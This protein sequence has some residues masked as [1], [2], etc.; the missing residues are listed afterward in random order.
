VGARVSRP[1]LTLPVAFTQSVI[2]KVER[3]LEVL[4]ALEGDPFL[5]RM[6]VLHGGTALN[7]FHDEVPRLSVDIDLM[8]TGA[9]DL[10]T[11]REMRPQVDTR[12]RGVVAALGYAVQ[13]TNDEH[14]GQTYRVKYGDEYIK[15]DVSYLARVALLDPELPRCS[16]ADPPVVFPTLRLPELVSGKIKAL[17]ERR[18]AR[19]LYDLYR[20]SC[21]EPGLLEDP[22]A[23][24]L[25]VRAV[26]V[27]DPFPRVRTPS[28]VLDVLESPPSEYTEPLLAMLPAG[29]RPDYAEMLGA[30]RRWLSALDVTTA[31]E[32]EFMRLLDE[33][34]EYRPQL[35]FAAWPDVLKRA[36]MDP[37]MAWKLRNL[38][39][40]SRNGK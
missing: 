9:V 32:A 37:V 22:L 10:E 35:L 5:G 19:D 31:A 25:A 13:G 16:L 26:S 17:V 20:L 28:Q 24:A 40:R 39:R 4:S 7:L 3:L 34:A 12:F 8:F 30:V 2:E 14:S 6:F 11:M 38:S 33:E 18:A 27:S 36:T 21:K 15:V 1:L 29:E 23:R